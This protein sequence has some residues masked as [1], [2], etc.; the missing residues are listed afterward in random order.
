MQLPFYRVICWIYEKN[1]YLSL[2]NSRSRY[3]DQEADREEIR[4]INAHR[5]W[6]K[7]Q[8]QVYGLMFFPYSQVSSTLQFYSHPENIISHKQEGHLGSVIISG[9]T[10]KD[11]S[12]PTWKGPGH[13]Y[14]FRSHQQ[15]S[16]LCT[17]GRGRHM[18]GSYVAHMRNR[19]LYGHFYD[20]IFWELKQ[21]D[22]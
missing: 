13:I 9:L 3:C 20:N 14:W 5:L 1:S 22:L 2:S 16:A 7:C 21:M 15:Q 17:R 12:G 4:I 8:E 18:Q 6:L 10:L 11:I 19:I